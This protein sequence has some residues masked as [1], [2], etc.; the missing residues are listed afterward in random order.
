MILLKSKKAVTNN[1]YEKQ[2]YFV[3]RKIELKFIRSLQIVMIFFILFYAPTKFLHHILIAA[4]HVILSTDAILAQRLNSESLMLR[5]EGE[6][7]IYVFS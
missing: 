1:L 4:D 5:S 6:C 7:N 3:E 2:Q